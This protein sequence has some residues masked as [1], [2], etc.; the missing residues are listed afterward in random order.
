MPNRGEV[1]LFVTLTTISHVRTNR[2]L[3]AKKTGPIHNRFLFLAIRD[4][5]KDCSASPV[6]PP[7]LTVSFIEPS[8][9]D[10][11]V[12]VSPFLRAS[13]LALSTAYDCRKRFK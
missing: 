12:I 4:V 2:G 3:P 13:S 8:S 7:T 10:C 9:S 11:S 1:A 5:V 6:V